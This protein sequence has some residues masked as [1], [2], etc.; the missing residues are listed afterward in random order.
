MAEL[1]PTSLNTLPQQDFVSR[2]TGLPV[3]KQVTLL[4]GLAATIALGAAIILWTQAPTYTILFAN[5]APQDAQEIVNKLEAQKVKYQLEGQG[6]ILVPA[7]IVHQLRM[8]MAAEGV[9]AKSPTGYQLLDRDQ[10]FGISQFRETT[11]YHRAIEGELAASIASI[12]SVKSA[13]VHLALPKRSVFV[14][15]QQEPSAS[16]VLDLRSGASLSEEQV[17]AIVYLVANSIPDMKPDNVSVVD[18]KGNLLTENKVDRGLKLNMKQREYVQTL[19]DDLTQ[20]IIR[21]LSPIVGGP[22]RV[23][24][25]VTAEVD[26]TQQEL[27][28]ENYQPDPNAIRSEQQIREVNKKAGPEGVPGALTNQPPQAGIAPETNYGGNSLLNGGDV[29]SGSEKV[30][31][32][33]E[34]DRTISHVKN[35]LGNIVRMSVA[36]VV[37]D[38]TSIGAD[39]TITRTP[40][41]EQEL[42]QIQSL[43]ADAVALDAGRGDKLSVLNV[44]FVPEQEDPVEAI[45]IWEQ[46]W[47]WTLVKQVLG[48]LAVLLLI[49]G[50]LR[51]LLK[52]VFGTAESN[53][54]ESLAEVDLSE[55]DPELAAKEE[56]LDE[57]LAQM[58]E[59]NAAAVEAAEQEDQNLIDRISEIVDQDPRV[60]A[61]VIREWLERR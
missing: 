32:N 7:E 57:A 16:V 5:L 47:F 13:R 43:V 3:I 9:P 35:A 27:T 58:S 1:T 26:F 22:N 14:R 40:M 31:R 51:P 8:Q 29:K 42:A 52:Q 41:S 25:Q 38:K 60:A 61:L 11:Q 23:R 44:A 33:Y 2:L 4:I 37:D 36:V 53:E 21:L 48:V 18:Q 20:R 28:R 49:F 19:E 54:P 39:G 50:V 10:G 56:G 12:D 45:P 59:E 15:K 24:A 55:L 17:N 30:I 46:P 6:S 34:M